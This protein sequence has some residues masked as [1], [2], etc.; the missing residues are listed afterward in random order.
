MAD[1]SLFDIARNLTLQGTLERIVFH[2]EENGYTVFRLA[3]EGKADPTTVVGYINMPQVGIGVSV[4]GEFVENSRFGRQ[5]KMDTYEAVLPAT[6]EGMRHYLGS[7]LVKGVGAALAKRIV[8]MF[9]EDTF[10]VI[11][12]NPD[13]LTSV[14]GISPRIASEIK[15]AWEE[16]VG[17]RDLIMFLQPHGVS[18]SL[19]VRIYKAYGS[20]ALPTVKENPYRLAMDIRGIGFA[21]ADS[22][23]LKI[24]LEH[25]SPLRAEAGLLY[26]LQRLTT[27]GNVFYP[28]EELVHIT[29]DELQQTVELVREAVQSLEMD[30]R[31][32]TERLYVTEDASREAM[33]SSEGASD[34]ETA[35]GEALDGQGNG[36]ALG[37]VENGRSGQTGR[38]V[39]GGSAYEL[40]E[41]NSFVAVYLSMYHHCECKIAYYL[42]RIVS[43][44]KSVRFQEP[45]RL[46]KNVLNMLP[47]ALAEEQVEAARQSLS[48]KVVVVTG[49]PGTGKTT[50]INA[51][52]QLFVKEKGKV[53]LCA[54]TGRA[55]K[56]MAETSGMESRTIH[57]L[58]EY[59][60]AE[61]GFG[62]NE[63][64]PLAC[65]LLVVDEASMIDT[66]LLFHL[67]KAV[68]LG[69]T[70]VLV[71]DINQL[72]SVGAGSV[73][74]DIMDSGVVDVVEL[75][76]VFRQAAESDI[77]VNAHRINHGEVPPLQRP[78]SGLSDFYFIRQDDPEAAADMVVDLVKNHIPRRFG[79]D[80]LDDIQVLTPMHKGAAGVQ[81]LNA[82]LQEALNPQQLSVQRGERQFRLDDKVM[83]IRNNYEKDVFNGDI[84]RI[85]LMNKEERELVVRYEER[86]VLYSFDE[87]DEIYP[88]YAVSVHKSQGSEY[89][90]VVIPI[91]MQHYMLLQRNL[92]Y[93]GVTRGKKLVVLVG[94]V[95]AL[96][97]AVKNNKTLKRYTWL[98]RRLSEGF[99]A[100]L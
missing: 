64:N 16:H 65:S 3:E 37:A 50:V 27:D 94:S 47:I 92:V 86:N 41:D 54:P 63:N 99:T 44:P 67:L 13:L 85:C 71:G 77:I 75:T 33:L 2:N 88:A 26:T 30:G 9:K 19:A 60:P 89:P 36:D 100:N 32:V 23:A 72:P 59:S 55:A 62:R 51:I 39:R 70:L 40:D 43:S 22:I 52:I 87:L 17:I 11:D 97:I 96:S 42:R 53:L 57:R 15:G 31:V 28:L 61:D 38:D 18:T 69:A 6:A 24:G 95:K 58:L 35:N 74:K 14:K 29:A 78:E 45:E 76:E 1:P 10:K 66:M 20:A 82:R 68:P 12:E 7:G 34:S 98:A 93:T 84:G 83:Q 21:T 73:L 79:F 56:R 80:P 90:A 25:N 5:F 91:M 81:N 48:G 49:G 8:D 4:T 46:L